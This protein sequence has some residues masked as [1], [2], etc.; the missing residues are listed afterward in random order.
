MTV[1]TGLITHGRIPFSTT[2]TSLSAGAGGRGK[3][4]S[5]LV[6][7]GSSGTG[8]VAVQMGKK[9][10]LKVVASCSTKNIDFVRSLGADEVNSEC[11]CMGE[12]VS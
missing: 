6:L 7:G 5:L 2:A 12:Y 4:R 11:H 3:Q 10:G 8:S 1:Y 9:L